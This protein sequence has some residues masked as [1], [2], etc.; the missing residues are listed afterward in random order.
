VEPL[1][2]LP[3]TGL[4]IL[5][6]PAC[7]EK[8]TVFF[9]S[10]N[11]LKNTNMDRL[12]LCLLPTSRTFATVDAIVLT[13]KF[14]IT[15]QVTIS[16]ERSAKSDGF[17]TIRASLPT[18]IAENEWCHVFITDTD[19]HAA[20]LRNQTLSEVPSNIQIYSGVFDVDRRSGISREHLEAFDEHKVSASWLH[21][22]VAYLGDNDN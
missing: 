2:C 4:S 14:I 9:G 8:Q 11:G 18:G 12:P 10:K 7:G 16:A 21:V 15:I 5:Q 6:I 20:S 22:V 19:D 13:D 3:K 1:S 17:A